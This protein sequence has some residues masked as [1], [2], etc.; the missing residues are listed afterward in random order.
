MSLYDVLNI[1]A[2]GIQNEKIV[3]KDTVMDEYFKRFNKVLG[4]FDNDSTG[5]ELSEVYTE[6]YG[7]RCILS[8]FEKSKDFSAMIK[9]EGIN[10][11]TETIL[12]LINDD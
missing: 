3:V 4:F 2:V 8:P 5:K 1:S 10:T 11:S 12:K 7:I 6:K 9:N